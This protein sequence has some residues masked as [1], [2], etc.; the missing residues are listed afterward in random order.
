[1]HRTK[2]QRTVRESPIKGWNTEAHGTV[3]AH[4]PARAGVP[5]LNP[6]HFCPQLGALLNTLG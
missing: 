6:R 3:R 4:P 2:P 1:M 5:T